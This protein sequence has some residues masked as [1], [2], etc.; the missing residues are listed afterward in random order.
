MNKLGKGRGKEKH[1]APWKPLYWMPALTVALCFL[2]AQL[3]LWKKLPEAVVEIIPQIIGAVTSFLGA[4][5]GARIASRQRFLWG[6]IN[7][8]SYVVLLM[9][10]NVLFFGE[11]FSGIGTMILWVMSSGVM[12]SLMANLKKSKIA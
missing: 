11:P 7:A 5:S 12:G 4:Y 2:S 6:I 9:I 3:I 1:S 10:G 8:G